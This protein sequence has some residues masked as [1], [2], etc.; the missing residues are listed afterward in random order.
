MLDS[1][2]AQALRG[3]KFAVIAL[4]NYSEN[5]VCYEYAR[6]VFHRVPSSELEASQK[7]STHKPQKYIPAHSSSAAAFIASLNL[8]NVLPPKCRELRDDVQRP[9]RR[10]WR[11]RKDSRCDTARWGFVFALHAEARKRSRKLPPMIYFQVADAIAEMWDA[12]FTDAEICE[13]FAATP[14]SPKQWVKMFR[15]LTRY[16]PQQRSLI[17]AE[18][19][20]AF[21]RATDIATI[22]DPGERVNAIRSQLLLYEQERLAQVSR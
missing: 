12:S 3:R 1:K 20:F 8:T 11:T 16:T 13:C 22:S 2:A 19:N 21:A 14:A 18:H 10:K 7:V 9:R 6:P 15:R 5:M 17:E 4:P